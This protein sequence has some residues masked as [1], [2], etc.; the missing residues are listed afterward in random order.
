MKVYIT[1]HALSKG[2]REIKETN[3][4]FFET[5]ITSITYFKK[6]NDPKA[7]N[8]KCPVSFYYKPDWHSTKEEA[9]ERA[10]QMRIQE[11]NKLLRKVKK[12]Q[13]LKFK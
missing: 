7:I 10:E 6:I 13:N 2:I 9:I 5:N 12:L 4:Y 3:D 11:I 8:D 1:K